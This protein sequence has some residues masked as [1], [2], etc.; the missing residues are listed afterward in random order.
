VSDGEDGPVVSVIVPVR[1]SGKEVRMLVDALAAQ[2]IPRSRFEIVVGDDGSTDGSTEG[3]ETPDGWVRVFRG[4]ARNA[5]AARNRAVGSARGTALAFVDGDCMPE[6]QWLE[7]GVERLEQADIVAGLVRFASPER[8]TIWT[9]LDMDLHLNQRRAV[10][11]GHAVTANLFIRRDV[12]DAAG[13]FDSV[14]A[15]N[16][17]YRLVHDC[18]RA[19]KQLVFDERAAVVHPT[20]NTRASLLGKIWFLEWWGGFEVGKEGRWPRLLGLRLLAPIPLTLY[21]R[22]RYRGSLSLDRK[23]LAESGVHPT[24]WDRI[25]ALPYLYVVVPFVAAT[26]T[27][28]GWWAGRRRSRRGTAAVEVADSPRSG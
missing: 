20:R 8:P 17:D 5:Y 6:P 2:T 28:S 10:R 9:L 11:Y 1:N 3:L 7:A 12:F 18:V 19:G 26:A 15:A 27:L 16:E 14:Y 4:E 21:S 22:W 23:R 13:G 24:V 25:R